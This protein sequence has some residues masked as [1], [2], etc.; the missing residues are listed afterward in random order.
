MHPTIDFIKSLDV[1]ANTTRRFTCP[2]CNK[3]NTLSVT[4]REGQLMWNC[5][6]AGCSST[7]GKEVVPLNVSDVQKKLRALATDCEFSVPDH[8]VSIGT[9]EECIVYL[10]KNNSLDAHAQ[11]RADI[12]YDPKENRIVFMVKD[13]RGTIVDACGRTFYKNVKPKWKRYGSS[14]HPFICGNSSTAIIVEDC[15]SACSVSRVATG[16]AL[17]GT[18]LQAQHKAFIKR[19][20]KVIIALDKDATK[21]AIDMHRE[22]SYFAD[23]TVAMLDD[24]LKYAT[25]E[26]ILD[27]LRVAGCPVVDDRAP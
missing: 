12:R 18:S 8:F 2:V 19:F 7:R 11:K 9:R 17:M 16:I 27:I 4:N 10:G 14:G 23:T 6:Y 13:D 1:P 21:K 20:D 26:D 15:P 3:N 25:Q 24:D 22:V 5:F